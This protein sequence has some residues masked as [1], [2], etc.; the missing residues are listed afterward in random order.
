M[1]REEMMTPPSAAIKPL[2]AK[3]VIRVRPTG[4]PESRAASSLPPTL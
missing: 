4:M 3:I 2:M 1:M